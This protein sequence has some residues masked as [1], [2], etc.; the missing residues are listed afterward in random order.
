[1][2]QREKTKKVPTESVKDKKEPIVKRD[3]GRKNG[4]N[5]QL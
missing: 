3:R 4:N 2:K 5:K 1:M